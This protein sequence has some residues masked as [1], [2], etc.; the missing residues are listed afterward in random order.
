MVKS[1][2]VWALDRGLKIGLGENKIHLRIIKENIV[3]F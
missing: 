2:S 3:S 1:V